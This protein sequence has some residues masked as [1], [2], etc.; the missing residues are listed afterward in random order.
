MDQVPPPGPP[1]LFHIRAIGI[2]TLLTTFD[3][4]LVMYSLE[5]ILANGVSAMVLFGSEYLILLASV[6]GTGARYAVNVI[7]IRRARGRADAPSWEEKSMWLF[8]IDLAVGECVSPSRA[9]GTRT[10]HKLFGLGV[11]MV[12][13]GDDLGCRAGEMVYSGR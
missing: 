2:I 5:T 10:R 7:D 11:Y 12:R 9:F 4:L 3:L 13:P 8:Y 1:I 6:W